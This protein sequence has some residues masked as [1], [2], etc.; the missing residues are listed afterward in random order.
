MSA[1][2]WKR[3]L[4]LSAVC[5]ITFVYPTHGQ[6]NSVY[7][8]PELTVGPE[9]GESRLPDASTSATV[10]DAETIKDNTGH[11]FQ[12]VLALVPN[13]AWSGGT[14]RPRYFLIRGVGERSQ[15]P[16]EGPPNFSVGFIV[17]DIDFNGVGMHSS[18]F[19]VDTVE[20][21]RGP[22]AA[23]YGSRALA[24]LVNIRT[25]DPTPHYEGRTEI[26]LGTDDYYAIGVAAGG[27]L[28]SQDPELLSARV[29][30][31]KLQMN[32]FRKNRFL[33][34]DDTNDRDE[35]TTRAKLRWHPNADW[36]WDLAG[37]Y[38]YYNNGYD[39][40][41][42]DNNGFDMF[43][44]EPGK[45]TQESFGGSL[46][47][48]WLGP[49]PYRLL[50]IS[51]F[52]HSDIEYGYDADWGNDA[53]WAA[54]PYFWD[55]AVEG[56]RYSFTEVVF[57]N[58]ENFGQDVRLISEPGGEILGGSS[59]WNLGIHLNYLGEDDDYDGFD[60]FRSYY[61]AK[62]AAAYGQ[63]S[64][65]LAP[66]I[67]LH[68]SLR[69]EERWTDYD[70]NRGVEFDGSD[71]MWG[72]RLALETKVDED[73][74]VFVGASRGFKGGGANQGPDVPEDRRAFD[75]ETLWNFETG[76]RAGFFDN[77]TLANLTLFYMFRDDLQITTSF[78][79]DPSD[80]TAFTFFTDNAAEGHNYG[81]ELELIQKL[82][83]ELQLI[84]NLGV[85][86][87]EFSNFQS[88]GGVN[89]VDDRDQP[90]APNYTALVGSRYAH[91]SGFFAAAEVEARD[92]FF[93]S[94]SHDQRSEP[95]ELF[96]ARV[97]YG[98]DNWTLTLWGRN[99]F[100]KTYAVRGFS[101]GLEPPDFP[102]TLYTA[103]GDPQQFGATLEVL[104]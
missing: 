10:F 41:V 91:E 39:Q 51:S 34:R 69:V 56:F 14:S 92:A 103:A 70:D 8:L 85:L 79:A 90:Y 32:G 25:R 5:T 33:G 7:T 2:M 42:P 54:A 101:F 27:P 75:P 68:S 11:H 78:Q 47:G 26:T 4:V 28:S 82:T 67:V 16:G 100:D 36:R 104:F 86:E 1:R 19:D 6:E 89:D 52:V 55:P 50:S 57:R 40:F 9:P 43:T 23:I 77:R 102:D 59:A 64:S 61:K 88:A 96:H 17:D 81:L 18:M 44:D 60:V 99:I 83:S 87:T 95:Y 94:D 72:G 66:A 35:L 58:R 45:D 12:D 71:T 80:P 49:N 31:Q 65:L 73:V 98:R 46:R 48:T 30:V 53:F 76:T 15:F 62:S 20:V 93:F 74:M 29:S 3:C 22:Q 63:L 37:I 21:L 13:L 84:G 97:G 24:G 38:S